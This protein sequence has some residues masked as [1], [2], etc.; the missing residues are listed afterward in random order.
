MKRSIS[1]SQNAAYADVEG[2]IGLYCLQVFP[3]EGRQSHYRINQV[4]HLY[5][6]EGLVPFEE[7]PHSYNPANEWFVSANNKTIGNSFP[8]YISACLIYLIAIIDT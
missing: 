8:H 7:L 2:N 4:Y 5:D 3:F 1:V 6:W